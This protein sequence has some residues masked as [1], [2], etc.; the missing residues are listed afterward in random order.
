VRCDA[1]T[2]LPTRAALSGRLSDPREDH[3]MNRTA[4]VAAVSLVGIGLAFA[5]V[6]LSLWLTDPPAHWT[7]IVFN[8]H[9]NLP[10]RNVAVMSAVWVLFAILWAAIASWLLR[11]Q[12]PDHADAGATD[13]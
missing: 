8:G 7:V 11:R 12:S 4:R 9:F 3:A 1:R 6:E 2:D 13:A 5:A 10:R